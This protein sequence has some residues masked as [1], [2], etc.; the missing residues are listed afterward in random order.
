M[1]WGELMSLPFDPPAHEHRM[2]HIGLGLLWFISST[3]Y[4][5]Q[6]RGHEHVLLNVFLGIPFSLMQAILVNVC[7]SIWC[8]GWELLLIKCNTE[9]S[10]PLLQSMSLESEVQKLWGICPK[11]GQRVSS[12]VGVITL[13]FLIIYPSFTY[14]FWIYLAVP[15]FSCGI[16]NL[17]R[18]LAEA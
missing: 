9:L 17:I 4:N 3:F 8:R 11:T 10:W 1:N 18:I 5:F 12:F 7:R 16:W 13:S 15:C 14:L 6:R 2:S